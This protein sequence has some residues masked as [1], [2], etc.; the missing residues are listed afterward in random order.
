MVKV[1]C[2][3]SD[4]EAGIGNNMLF[5][6]SPGYTFG[7][8]LDDACKYWRLQKYS[9]VNDADRKNSYAITD[10]GGVLRCVSE[11]VIQDGESNYGEA[12]R[13]MLIEIDCV[14]LETFRQCHSNTGQR[15]ESGS[16]R[17]EEDKDGRKEEMERKEKWEEREEKED[18]DIFA[19]QTESQNEPD[20]DQLI[21]VE[22]PELRLRGV[23]NGPK[24]FVRDL[25]LNITFIILVFII[26]AASRNV[27]QQ[28][29]VAQNIDKHLFRSTFL[30]H[31][32]RLRQFKGMRESEDWWRWAAGPL[33]K[34]FS[35]SRTIAG[36][37]LAQGTNFAIG[38][39]RLQQLRARSDCP[40]SLT[41]SILSVESS[42]PQGLHQNAI[43][44]IHGDPASQIFC[45]DDN[46]FGEP[47]R[48]NFSRALD[49]DRQRIVWVRSRIPDSRREKNI[50]PQE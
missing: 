11:T 39:L 21:Q 23:L 1:E 49:D 18:G 35:P 43:K 40:H 47:L 28:Y 34:V 10:Q 26:T 8:L 9:N 37:S 29:R 48:S 41:E 36:E 2:I 31:G 44:R 14:P 12:N 46:P 20:E 5:F 45:F 19:E 17:K 13:Y 27:R 7:N 42:R 50:L 15:D 24:N 32:D 33:A 6:A 38:G 25:L 4:M 30:S 16:Q 3:S 22:T